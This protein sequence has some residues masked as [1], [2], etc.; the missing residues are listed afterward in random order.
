M[1]TTRLYVVRESFLLMNQHV[2]FQNGFWEVVDDDGER[3]LCEG[4]DDAV[5]LATCLAATYGSEVVVHDKE[6]FVRQRFD[7]RL[8]ERQSALA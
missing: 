4:E 2:V 7:P 5:L 3:V 6:G 8:L 1:P